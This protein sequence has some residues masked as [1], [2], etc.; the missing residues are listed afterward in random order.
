MR[1]ARLALVPLLALALAACQSV[2]P[3]ASA[4]AL[5]AA[6]APAGG[7]RLQQIVASGSLRVGLSGDQPPFNMTARDGRVIG[8]E[9]DVVKA[10]GEALGLEVQLV[11]RPFDE[12]LPALER[13]EL[14]LVMSGVTI[15]AERN[16]RVAFVGPYFVSG[17]SLLTRKPE[18]AEVGSF[19]ALDAPGRRFVALAGSTS[20]AQARKL[21]PRAK[22]EAVPDYEAG[23]EK[24]RSGRADALIADFAICQVT[25]WRNPEAGLLT[26]STPLT[27]E[28]LGIALPPDD[29]L[30]VNLVENHLRTLEYTGVLTQLKARWLADT[31]WLS[32]LP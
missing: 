26:L 14:D 22:V 18:L 9:V 20:E 13:G 11:R 2:A 3:R 5:A 29:P 23:V 32:E 12:L 28:P 16:A 4:P 1:A 30:L 15:T 7:G 8:F 25:V 19:V 31:A 21:L 10:L 6:Q 24:V 17:K 27:A